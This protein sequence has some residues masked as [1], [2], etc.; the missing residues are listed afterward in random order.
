MHE[1]RDRHTRDRERNRS[2]KNLDS[3]DSLDK[4]FEK[5]SDVSKGK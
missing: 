1:A 5:I 4:D 2:S 3:D